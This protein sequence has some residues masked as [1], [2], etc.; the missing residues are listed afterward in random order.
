[1]KYIQQLF[2]SHPN[3]LGRYR[4]RYDIRRTN[5][6]RQAD[7]GYISTRLERLVQTFEVKRATVNSIRHA[8]S[9]ELAAQGFDGKTINVFTHHTTDSM[10]NQNF[11]IST[12]NREQDSIA[13]ALAS[14]HSE[15]QATQ[16][17]PKQRYGARV[18]ERDEL[19]QFLLGDDL[20]LSS[21]ETPASPLSLPIISTKSIVEAESLNDHESAK[22][23]KSK[24]NKDVKDVEPQKE[25]QTSSITKD[26]DRA[27]IAE[28]QK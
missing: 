20:K 2:A 4:E 22:V 18:S 5:D 17:I 3:N 21:Q 23:Q 9:T 8:S 27:T 26:S 13:S 16:T 12:V 1:M 15:K 14:N 11:Y 28:V 25:I 19:Q 7:H 24:T 10:M 6:R